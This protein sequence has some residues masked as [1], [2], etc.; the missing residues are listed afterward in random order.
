M[1]EHNPQNPYQAKA[2]QLREL[3]S[4]PGVNR[5]EHEVVW[6]RLV[7]H[8]PPHASRV[9]DFGCGAGNFTHEL[10]HMYPGAEV[11]GVDSAQDMMPESG[12]QCAF[13]QWDGVCDKPD[14]GEFDLIVAKMS[15]HYIFGPDLHTVA[16]NLGKL[17]TPQGWLVFSVPHPVQPELLNKWQQGG[18]EIYHTA[19]SFTHEIGNTGIAATMAHRKISE[20]VN[21][22]G[23][24]LPQHGLRADEVGKGHD[25]KRLIMVLKPS[26]NS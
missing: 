1:V 26:T 20:W 4:D 19:R 21:L 16:G 24:V 14:I 12:G 2:Q 23:D 18:R 7:A 25:F 22:F 11:V 6:P 17:L 8:L 13:L 5:F 10:A 3:L 9:L 15:L